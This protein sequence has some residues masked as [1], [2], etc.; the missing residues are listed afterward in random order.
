[1]D[2]SDQIIAIPT[3]VKTLPAPIRTQVGHLSDKERGFDRLDYKTGLT[4]CLADWKRKLEIAAL[5][6]FA[7]DP[8]LPIVPLN[9]FGT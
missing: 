6:D 4:P 7:F 2:A 5:A 8:D 3:L 1:V 9:N